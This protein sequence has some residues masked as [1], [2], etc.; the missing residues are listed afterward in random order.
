MVRDR[1]GRLCE[2][3]GR[4]QMGDARVSAGS[5][6]DHLASIVE[7]TSVGTFENERGR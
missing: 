1:V 6:V 2:E 4:A 7:D 5:A 3:M